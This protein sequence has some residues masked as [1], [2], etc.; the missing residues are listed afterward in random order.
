MID[1]TSAIAKAKKEVYSFLDSSTSS[2]FQF[3]LIKGYYIMYTWQELTQRIHSHSHNVSTVYMHTLYAH[4]III[5]VYRHTAHA[6][7]HVHTYALKLI[8]NIHTPGHCCT[9]GCHGDYAVL[10]DN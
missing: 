4:I 9:T 7:L 8:C 3:L 6:K 2:I 10:R 1:K 5:T